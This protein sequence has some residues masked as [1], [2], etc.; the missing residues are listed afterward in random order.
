M[1]K[2]EYLNQ[3]K[4]YLKRLPKKD[5]DNAMDYF[6]E[7]FDEVGVEGEQGAM[8]EL[9]SPKAAA[10]ELLGNLLCDKVDAGNEM[11]KQFPMGRTILIACLA[12]LAA[13]IG[14]P[15]AFTAL[16]LIFSGVLII[17]IAILCMFIFSIA[18]I[19]IAGKLLLR[20]IVAIPFSL[21]GALILIGAGILGI[22]CSILL[23]IFVIYL[24]ELMGK[25]IKKFAQRVIKKRERTR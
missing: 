6:I 9:G 18:F 11:K 25:G 19:I 5:Y 15:L 23:A 16:L 10:A 20:G 24:C 21:P 14:L 1:S 2:T 8:L 13:P 17:A 12:I 7:Y 3:L 22:G 4:K